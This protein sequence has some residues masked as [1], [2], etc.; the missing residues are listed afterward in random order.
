MHLKVLQI[1]LIFISFL[2]NADGQQLLQHYKWLNNKDHIQMKT[3]YHI[4]DD[5]C[6][7][8]L[9][10]GHNDY[11]NCKVAAIITSNLSYVQN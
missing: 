4:Y 1:S 2:Y 3:R 5:N 6:Y 8:N 7:T 9:R 10:W 11:E